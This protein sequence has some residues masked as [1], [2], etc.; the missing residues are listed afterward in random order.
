MPTYLPSLANRQGLIDL[1]APFEG[2]A[3]GRCFVMGT[4]P[5]LLDISE[6]LKTQLQ[7]E[8]TIG[9]SAFATIPGWFSPTYIMCREYNAGMRVEA[10]LGIQRFDGEKLL[11]LPFLSDPGIIHREPDSEFFRRVQEWHWIFIDP[12]YSIEDWEP[13]NPAWRLPMLGH[14]AALQAT[15][16]LWWMG[17]KEIY[18]LGCDNTNVGYAYDQAE[19]RPWADTD[20]VHKMSL[21][22]VNQLEGQGVILK[23]C[24]EGGR[25]PIPKANLADVLA[26]KSETL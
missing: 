21:I 17:F 1:L 11:L 7:Q 18:L 8:V 13:E 14:N 6:E 4:G 15:L 2:V 25:L 5:S 23:D 26:I 3:S 19:K 20:I 16:M 24:T 12:T 9:V 10:A 22:L